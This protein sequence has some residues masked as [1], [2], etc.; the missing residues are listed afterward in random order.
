MAQAACSPSTPQRLRALAVDDEPSFLENLRMMLRR[1]GFAQVETAS[2]AESAWDVLQESVLEER[3]VQLI[4]SDWNM[5]PT[6]G[7]HLLRRVR[8]HKG[9]AQTPFILVTGSL[10]EEAWSGAISCGAT[11][12]LNKPFSLET[13]RESVDIALALPPA[14]AAVAPDN[15]VPFPRSR[16]PHP[17][18]R[19]Q[20]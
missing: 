4:V 5:E 2:D 7:L 20:G 12:F 3:P 19:K 13:L 8:A 6:S 14:A 11:D 10:S 9:L 15:L 16:M 1:C 18:L 17:I